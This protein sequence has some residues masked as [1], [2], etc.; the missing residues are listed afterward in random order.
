MLASLK[1]INAAVLASFFIMY[2]VSAIKIQPVGT[3]RVCC[4][5]TSVFTQHALQWREGKYDAT[6][7]KAAVRSGYHVQSNRS[8]VT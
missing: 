5:V 2:G 1:G 7:C 3:T 6:S 8:K 4:G